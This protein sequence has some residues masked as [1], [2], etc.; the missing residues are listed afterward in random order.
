MKISKKCFNFEHK[1]AQNYVEFYYV[2]NAI[3]NFGG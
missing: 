3:N 2:G 1:N